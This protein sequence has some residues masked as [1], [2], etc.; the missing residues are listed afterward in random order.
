[1]KGFVSCLAAL[2]LLALAAAAAHGAIVGALSDW[3]TDPT[4][5]VLNP[6]NLNRAGNTGAV[7]NLAWQTFTVTENFSVGSVFVNMYDPGGTPYG[8][9][10]Y[11]IYPVADVSS[12]G[13]PTGPALFSY[14]RA[15]LGEDVPVDVE[16]TFTG[17]DVFAL[18]PGVY[19]MWIVGDTDQTPVYWTYRDEDV[20]ANGQAN[21]AGTVGDATLAIVAVPEPSTMFLLALGGL[22]LAC[23]RRAFPC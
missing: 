15:E 19:S 12:G 11:K 23:R 18:T 2:L 1:M 14:T 10:T 17:P 7:H 20:Y 3:P 6:A 22:S 21:F 5:E 9:M 4:L 8:Y 16:L 13:V